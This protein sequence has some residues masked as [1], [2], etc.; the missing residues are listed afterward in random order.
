M[1]EGISGEFEPLQAHHDVTS[2]ACGQAALDNWLRTRAL[3]NQ[4]TGDS[5]TFV[6]AEN[7]R[8]IGF[9]A[10]TTASA[11]RV[12]LPGALRRNAPDPV[13]LML[14]GQ[15]AVATSHGGK[16]LGRR[17]LQDALIRAAAASRNVGFRALATHPIDDRAAAFYNRFG[18]TAVPDS[19]PRLMVLP[20]QRLLS[21]LD[22]AR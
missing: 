3:R 2:F 6:L 16:G 10:L 17:L 18:F 21:A 8:V 19:Q 4:N 12:G 15:L 9:C 11:A 14:L 5:R 13:S 1:S 7:G 22:A 20:L